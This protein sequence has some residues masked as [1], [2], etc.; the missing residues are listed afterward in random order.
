MSDDLEDQLAMEMAV[1]V[2]SAVAPAFIYATHQM[3]DDVRIAFVR[4][5]FSCL[6]GMAEHS[7]GYAASREA[8]ARAAALKPA[9]PNPLQ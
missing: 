2:A 4:T 3:P 5:F 6:A 1:R 9:T 7:V 8:L